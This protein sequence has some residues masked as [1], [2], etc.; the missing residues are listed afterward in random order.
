M[1]RA[2][3]IFDELM[4][5]GK[6]KMDWR[7]RSG[8]G[9]E[10]VP[11]VPQFQTFRQSKGAD[12][13]LPPVP[14][15]DF[16]RENS[17]A[18]N[19]AGLASLLGLLVGGRDAVPGVAA[20]FL[21][22]RGKA[23]DARFKQSVDLWDRKTRQVGRMM[24]QDNRAESMMWRGVQGDERNA[25]TIRN[26]DSQIENRTAGQ[27]FKEKKLGL[28]QTFRVGRQAEN[29]AFRQKKLETDDEAR[30]VRLTF[31]K[32]RAVKSRMM[33]R[34]GQLID[35]AANP[36]TDQKTREWALQQWGNINKALGMGETDAKGAPIIG[37]GGMGGLTP[38]QKEAGERAEKDRK[39]REEKDQK[40]R[41]YREAR[42]K[43]RDG[44]SDRDYAERLRHNKAVE[45]KPK[46]GGTAD[47]VTKK[48]AGHR[49]RV[50]EIDGAINQARQEQIGEKTKGWTKE[51]WDASDRR[52]KSLAA[53]RGLLAAEVVR[54]SRKQT[55]VKAAA[56][57]KPGAVVG[58]TK[59]GTTWRKL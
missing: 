10:E 14:V 28:D 3:E 58:K 12:F 33:S 21:S 24:D 13:E 15:R 34:A 41:A 32:E 22:G 48:I 46:A 35:I 5:G 53:E 26:T 56:P 52:I 39:A 50:S 7:S 47:D 9:G 38:A 8:A 30:G 19:G 23:D 31:G 27:T 37:P 43:R 45:T 51:N 11:F 1:K 36:T 42:D 18:L 54:L 20:S 25:N 55:P 2:S 17:R 40:D 6:P 57:V 49:R 59:S 4:N 29:E 44:E 16:K